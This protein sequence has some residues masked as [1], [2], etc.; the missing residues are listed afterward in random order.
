MMQK[1]TAVFS[2]DQVAELAY[3]W[4]FLGG[5]SVTNGL[6]TTTNNDSDDA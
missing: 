4:P 2:H 6:A 3:L 5:K 1:R